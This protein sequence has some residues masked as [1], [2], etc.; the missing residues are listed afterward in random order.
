MAAART[1]PA[2]AGEQPVAASHRDTARRARGNVVVDL[3]ATFA[4]EARQRRPAPRAVGDGPGHV[5]LGRQAAQA[6][7]ERLGQGVDQWPAV[8]LSGLVSHIGRLAADL[9]PTI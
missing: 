7:V 9:G 5:G 6:G 4:Q 3:Q 1:A 2:R 8:L